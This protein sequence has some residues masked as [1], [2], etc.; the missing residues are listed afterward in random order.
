MDG[1]LRRGGRFVALAYR[2]RLVVV[3]ALLVCAGCG[4]KTGGPAFKPE[5]RMQVTVGGTTHWGMG[6]QK[7]A[8]LVA[9]KTGGAVK[10][11]PYFGGQLLR[12]AQLNAAQMVA[13]G[14]IDC[15]FES[16]INT[17]PVIPELNLFSLP[18]FVNS[19]EHVDR[20]EQGETGAVMFRAMRAV[21]LEPL[22]WGEN[23]FRQLTNSKRRVRRP[24]DLRG[25]RVRV[26]GTPLFT[27]IFRTLGADPINMNWGDAVT[28]FQQ[29]TVDGQENP[30]QILLAVQIHQYHDYQTLWNYA[31]DPLVLY[32]NRAQWDAFPETVRTALH[33]AAV[34]ACLYQ[35]ALAR[36]GLDD[37]RSAGVLK[38]VFGHEVDPADPVAFL[39]GKG[40]TIDTLDAEGRR[41]FAAAC[42]PVYD[43]WLEK[44][45][46][47]LLVMARA[48]MEGAEAVSG[49]R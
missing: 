37:G 41:A 48:D 16:T 46:D 32:W 22:G 33:D 27:D 40:M 39:R 29:G 25:L 4:Q 14:A 21:G 11:K 19:F 30:V 45:G 1:A 3:A 17:A 47:D 18:F 28:A 15:A 44:L 9:E 6:A 12:G 20:I 34:Q 43:T 31:I 23:G 7:F 38:T 42:R 13:T 10:V 2:Y 8:D 36:A 26:V 5:Y 49:G 24:E 35:K